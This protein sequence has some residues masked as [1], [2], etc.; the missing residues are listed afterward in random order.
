LKTAIL[1]EQ[2]KEH[3]ANKIKSRLSKRRGSFGIME[4]VEEI[5]VENL[6]G[7]KAMSPALPNLISKPSH[8]PDFDALYLGSADDFDE[9]EDI[10]PGYLTLTKGMEPERDPYEYTKQWIGE[11]TIPNYTSR[12]SLHQAELGKIPPETF[13]YADDSADPELSR[14]GR[15]PGRFGNLNDMKLTGMGVP[16]RP[17]TGAL[18][19]MVGGQRNDLG[20][21]PGRD[22]SSFESYDPTSC[23]LSVTSAGI[24]QSTSFVG[25]I[26]NFFFGR[27][28]GFS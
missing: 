25:S 27:K 24:S 26:A 22:S 13:S 17:G 16:G 23:E 20:T 19:V 12:P 9:L 4:T 10:E 7:D 3:K 15:G 2:R 18:G 5:G 14:R 21:I 8:L 28:G 6:M 1:G 11:L